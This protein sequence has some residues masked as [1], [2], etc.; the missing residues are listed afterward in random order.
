MANHDQIEFEMQNVKR[1]DEL[2]TK[3]LDF[4]AMT[5]QEMNYNQ[6]LN[7]SF[8]FMQT[9]ADKEFARQSIK[10]KLARVSK[11][12]SPFGKKKFSGGLVKHQSRV[13]HS[14]FSNFAPAAPIIPIQI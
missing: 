11:K 9:P 5:D 1:I 7:Y 8:K 4:R 2:D 13:Q 6:S 12:L 10:S 3:R 14:S